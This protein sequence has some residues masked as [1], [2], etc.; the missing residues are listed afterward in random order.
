MQLF[1]SYLKFRLWKWWNYY[2]SGRWL[3][4]GSIYT[5]QWRD[6]HKRR[7]PHGSV[8]K[9]WNWW[10]YPD[11][12]FSRKVAEQFFPVSMIS[13]MN[14]LQSKA[15]TARMYLIE[16]SL[17]YHSIIFWEARVQINPMNN[18]CSSFYAN[19]AALVWILWQW[20]SRQSLTCIEVS[21]HPDHSVSD[22]TTNGL[23]STCWTWKY[24]WL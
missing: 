3:Q 16:R 10:I 9:Y 1:A 7:R 17:Q 21:K 13:I 8:Y 2:Y 6:Q 22:P 20:K 12:L 4:A 11:I 14:T 23:F 5:W 15:N 18:H 24:L 19:M